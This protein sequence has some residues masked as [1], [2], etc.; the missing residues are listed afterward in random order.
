MM[1]IIIKQER[2]TTRLALPMNADLRTPNGQ[3]VNGMPQFDVTPQPPQL[4]TQG[5]KITDWTNVAY[6]A[7]WDGISPWV[8]VLAGDHSS[9]KMRY[10]GWPDCTKEEWDALHPV[11]PPTL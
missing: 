11:V 7:E 9:L 3:T 5:A 1:H 6:A 2:R 4:H 10:M 8:T